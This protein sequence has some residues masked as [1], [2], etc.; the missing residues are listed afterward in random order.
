MKEKSENRRT[1]ENRGS[2]I[3]AVVRCRECVWAMPPPSC[4]ESIDGRE[5]YKCILRG[6]VAWSGDY[7]SYGLRYDA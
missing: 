4:F 5:Y 1:E 2:D 3:V 7:C 6:A